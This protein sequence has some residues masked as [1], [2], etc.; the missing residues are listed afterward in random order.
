MRKGL[1]IAYNAIAIEITDPAGRPTRNATWPRGSR[2]NI[3]M[4]NQIL[5]A[6]ERTVAGLMGVDIEAL[7]AMKRNPIAGKSLHGKN[8]PRKA[9]DVSTVEPLRPTPLIGTPGAPDSG[10]DDED[11]PL[12]LI[13]RPMGVVFPKRVAAK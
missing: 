2:T 7:A 3:F 12:H 10:D 11:D 13:A 8:G 4:S 5:S 6:T 1:E 9:S